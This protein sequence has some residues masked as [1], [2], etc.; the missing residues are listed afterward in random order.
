M[1]RIRVGL[2]PG[3]LLALALAVAACG[4]GGRSN[5]VASLGGKATAT[6]S[7]GSGD[8]SR[9]RWP[10]PGACATRA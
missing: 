4:G 1:T 2:V 5:G 10:T 8:P 6:T 9:R 7:P 3:L